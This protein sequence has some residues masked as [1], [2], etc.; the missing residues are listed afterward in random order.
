MFDDFP[1]MLSSLDMLCQWQIIVVA[2]FGLVFG[3]IAGVIPGVNSALGI[4]V[5]LPLTFKMEPIVALILLTSVYAGGLTGGGILAILLNTPGAPA[6]VAT[7][8]DG[9]PMAQKGLV[10][11]ALGIQVFSST[12]GGIF[13][14]IFVLLLIRPMSQLALMFGPSEMMM[15]VILVFVVVSTLCGKSFLRSIFAGIF[16]LL[17]STIGVSG[18]TSMERGTMGIDAMLDGI[19]NLICIVGLF[20]IPEL[21][22]LT[23]KQSVIANTY[24]MNMSAGGIRKL[25]TGVKMAMQYKWTM[26]RSAVL[27]LVIGLLPAAG[28]AMASLLSYAT[29]KRNPKGQEVFGEGAPEGLVAAE[30]ANNASEG[31]AMACL[32]SLGIP[33]SGSTAVLLGAV[34]LHGLTPGPNL[35]Q[36]SPDLVYALLIGDV[37]GMIPMLFLALC[38]AFFTAKLIQI[39]NRILVPVLLVIIAMSAFSYRNMFFDV[40]L[41]M[42]CGILGWILRKLNFSQVNF[43]IGVLLGRNIED[44]LWR[45]ILLFGSDVTQFFLRP[46]T[47]TI[48][49]IIILFVLLH[50]YKTFFAKKISAY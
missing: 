31:G 15:L 28:S 10:N 20:S 26:F 21:I 47:G 45:S 42:S 8:F 29:A 23:Q 12:I 13:S 3:L 37:L 14:F 27:G 25:L 18:I 44:E 22:E 6:A 43:M 4:A 11:E 2:L 9:Y 50:I 33:G 24:H 34:F 16:G 46:L 39:P 30:T 19:P 7:T 36:N 17:V 49:I 48:T 35:L 38:V 5:L 1:L 40:F 32:L 41:L